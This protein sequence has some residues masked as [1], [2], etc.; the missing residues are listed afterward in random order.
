MQWS[1]LYAIRSYIKSSLWVVPFIAIPLELIATRVLHAIDDRS[2]FTLLGLGEGGA[3]AMLEVVITATLSFSVF[4]FGSLLVAIQVASGQLTPRIIATT[5]LRNNVVR[6]T[7]G[8]FIFTLFFAISASSRLDTDVRQLVVFTGALLGLFCFSAFLYLIDY[9]ARLLRPISILARVGND[10]LAVIESV[11]P[12]AVVLSQISKP[13]S[14]PLGQPDRVVRYVGTS[15]IVVAIQI[16]QLLSEA[17]RLDGVIEF[18]PQVGDFVAVE[19]PLFNLYG[20][21]ARADDGRL[22]GW[23]PSAPSAP[24][25]RIRHSRFELWSTLRCAR[26]PRRSTIRPPPCLLSISCTGCSGR[27]EGV[28]CAPTICLTNRPAACHRPHSQ[29]GGFCSSCCPRDPQLRRGHL[30]IVRRLRAMIDN[31]VQD[32]AQFG[33]QRCVGSWA[34]SIRRSEGISSIRK[35]SRLLKLG[36][37][38]AWEVVRADAR[39][40]PMEIRELSAPMARSG[41]FLCR[42]LHRESC[43]WWAATVIDGRPAAAAHPSSATGTQTMSDN[44]GVTRAN[45]RTPKAAAIAGIIFSIF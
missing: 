21:A 4:T 18:A 19:E 2:R 35:T 15:E 37:P 25:S 28:N 27:W 13:R 14:Q 41:S 26:Y 11:Y 20:G 38:K 34:C 16:G 7:V 32:F 42:V 43:A 40:H 33:G 36:I 24:W 39:R 3:R 6:Y 8:L 17:K 22:R 1:R 5:L 30:Q 29:L 31:L 12:D 45:L 23:L 9:A 44:A 10:G